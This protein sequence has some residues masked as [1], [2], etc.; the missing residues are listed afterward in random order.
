[1]L[2]EIHRVPEVV[3]FGPD[4]G[5]HGGLFA[6]K[7]S[8]L[9]QGTLLTTV[10]DQQEGAVRPFLSRISLSRLPPLSISIQHLP[11]VP[12]NDVRPLR[13]VNSNP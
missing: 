10:R 9:L 5:G 4:I 1:M 3:E 6:L 2:P 13:W 11:G 8:H 12:A 7:C